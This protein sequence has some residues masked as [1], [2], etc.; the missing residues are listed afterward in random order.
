MSVE[1]TESNNPIVTGNAIDHG[2][3]RLKRGWFIGYFID[4]AQ[5][6][7]YTEEI[8]VKW[9]IHSTSEEKPFPDAA[10]GTTLTLLIS[11][12][13]VVVF[14]ELNKSAYLKRSGD[15]VIFAPRVMH[16]W[17]TIEDSVV[18]NKREVG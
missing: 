11:G 2:D 9:G 14:P 1:M 16:S 8:E 15:Y 3:E 18:L 17:K 10:E 12:S 6:L 7:R 13:F 4:P 5:G